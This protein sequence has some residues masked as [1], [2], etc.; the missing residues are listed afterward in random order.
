MNTEVEYDKMNWL[1]NA[2]YGDMTTEQVKNLDFIK[3]HIELLE[4]NQL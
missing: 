4:K 1:Y 2:L 3:N